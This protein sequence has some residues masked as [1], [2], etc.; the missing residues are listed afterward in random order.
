V[1]VGVRFEDVK[2]EDRALLQQMV[3]A[4]AAKK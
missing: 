1:A 4:L 2:D 3:K